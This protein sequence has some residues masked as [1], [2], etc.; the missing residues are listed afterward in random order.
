MVFKTPR[1]QDFGL[2]NYITV[3]QSRLKIPRTS[4]QATSPKAHKTGR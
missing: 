3:T 2:E 4:N 1:D